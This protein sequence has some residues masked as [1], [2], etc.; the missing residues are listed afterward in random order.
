MKPKW[1]ACI[2]PL[3]TYLHCSQAH[4]QCPSIENSTTTQRYDIT[5]DIDPDLTRNPPKDQWLHIT[6][7]P[8]TDQPNRLVLFRDGAFF[9]SVLPSG[10]NYFQWPGGQLSYTFEICLNGSWDYKNP[11]EAIRS[12]I[13][14][15][16]SFTLRPADRVTAVHSSKVSLEWG[17]GIQ[18]PASQRLVSWITVSTG[19]VAPA[20]YV[21]A[22]TIVVGGAGGA[23]AD[24][25]TVCR[26]TVSDAKVPGATTVDH[27]NGQILAP[28]FQSWNGRVQQGTFE[29]LVAT[30]PSRVIWVLP[31]SPNE[32]VGGRDPST[33]R[34]FGI[35]YYT[36]RETV[37]HGVVVHFVYT[38]ARLGPSCFYT[39]EDR[40]QADGFWILAVDGQRSAD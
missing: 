38:G 11:Y 13:P 33:N 23:G 16:Q 35:C 27:R 30:D 28:C 24:L 6:Y 15:G 2:L 9:A 10:D 3:M 7:T 40:Q 22:G 17:T 36:K 1:T 14:G 5:S 8:T 21:H 19:Q 26:I 34:E 12:E 37:P 20:G 32:F 31:G 29:I 18:P 25:A 4:S 39:A